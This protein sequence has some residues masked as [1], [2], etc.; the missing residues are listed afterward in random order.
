[1]NLQKVEKFVPAKGKPINRRPKG[2]GKGS[3]NSYRGN[4]RSRVSKGNG[5][6]GG[7]RAQ[8]FAV[9]DYD[10]TYFGKGKSKK[11]VKARTASMAAKE[12]MTSQN[13]EPQKV[14]TP[15]VRGSQQDSPAI[16]QKELPTK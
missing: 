16:N 15:S 14:V 4:F 9:E 12:N 3:G 8:G 11:Q 6:K 10:A 13:V 5:A 7:K 1:M 2:K